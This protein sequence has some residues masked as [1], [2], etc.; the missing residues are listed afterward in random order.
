M[1]EADWDAVGRIFAAIHAR[2]AAAEAAEKA[3]QAQTATP[4]PRPL[5][6]PERMARYSTKSTA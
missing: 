2:R 1:T 4:S 3:R 6:R 5:P